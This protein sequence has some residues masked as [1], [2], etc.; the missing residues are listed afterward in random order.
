MPGF[1][2]APPGGRPGEPARVAAPLLSIFTVYPRSFG[3]L[4]SLNG[5][6]MAIPAFRRLL[7][8][9]ALPLVLV[10]CS[11]C[12]GEGK[13]AGEGG[14]VPTSITAAAMEYNAQTQIVLFNGNVHVKRPDFDLWAAKMTIY[15]DKS[16][17]KSTGQA[18]GAGEGMQAG[19]I[20]RI[21]AESGVRLKSADKE[22]VC[23][24]ATYYA[25]E[26]KIIMEGAPVVLRDKD[27]S[28]IKGNVV[29]HYLG[30]NRSEVKG[31]GGVEAVFFTPDKTERAS[32]AEGIDAAKSGAQ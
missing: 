28:T 23:D 22:G 18:T 3:N 24:K 26:D 13:T 7:F 16:A 29:T 10:P 9:L 25:K 4:S 2:H 17:K 1:A 30:T 11:P 21:V 20:D 14:K 31:R 12:A 19:D 5:I 15:L 8:A 32:G 27:K 6:L